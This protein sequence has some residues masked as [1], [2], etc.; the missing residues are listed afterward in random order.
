ML[1]EEPVNANVI[2]FGWS[3]FTL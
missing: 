1:S 3:E 2:V